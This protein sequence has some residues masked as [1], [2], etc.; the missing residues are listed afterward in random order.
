[1]KYIF[2]LSLLFAYISTNAQTYVNYAAGK[3][4]KTSWKTKNIS[5]M[6]D[7]NLSTGRVWSN[8]KDFVME[9]DLTAE[10]NIGGAQLY[11]EKAGLATPTDILIEY[12]NIKGEWIV[13]TETQVSKNYTY[14]LNLAFSKSYSTSAIRIRGKAKSA[15]GIAEVAIW[16]EQI[17]PLKYGLAFT[18]P[19]AFMPKEH[20]ICANQVTY[21][22]NQP[23]AFTV[24]TAK[25]DLHYTIVEAGT[26]LQ[27]YEA[28]L[29]NKK[30]VFSDFNPDDAEG[31]SYI[32]QIEGDGF[33][34]A[35]SYPFWIGEH[36]VQENAYQITTD[37]FTDV[38]SMVGTHRSAYGGSAWR[39]GAYYTYEVPSM[40]MMYLSNTR[41][42][43]EMN[44]TLDWEKEKKY[45][46]SESYNK[47]GKDQRNDK[48]A[49]STVKS[50]YADYPSPSQ[51]APDLIKNILF[52]TLWNLT[53]PVQSDPSGDKSGWMMHGQTVEQFAYFLYGYPEMEEYINKDIYAQILD[54]TLIWW[55]EVGLLDIIT[56]VGTGKGR[57]CPGHSIMPNLLMYEVAK[58]ENIKGAK[59]YLK[60]AVNQTQW[61]IENVDWS[62]P[63]YSKGQ[64]ISE[65]KLITGLALMQTNYSKESPKGLSEFLKTWVDR[66]IQLSDNEWDFR[67]FDLNENWTIPSYNEAGN[68]IA[69]PACALSVA[70][71]MENSPKKDRLVEIAYAHIDNY[72][73]RNP[74]NAHCA[75]HPNHG[76]T[77][78]ERGWQHGD[79]RRDICARLETTRGSLSSLPGSEMY[80]FNPL[81]KPRWGE[82]WTSYNALWNLSIT[83]LNFYEGVAD[84]EKIL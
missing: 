52:G 44:T 43:K 14:H 78:I 36:K 31:K 79:K 11:F 39:D 80:P 3:T 83:Y 12:K 32:I 49:L 45:V 42:F 7:E 58:R 37:F 72:S 35:S 21:N 77:G 5:L 25:T 26:G 4:V 2:I 71:T 29:K 47:Q 46:L 15:Y 65:H 8:A 19:V 38:R 17:P 73:G 16:G 28:F 82:G 33:P 6:T 62:D 57:H 84:I 40:V 50:I 18:P 13:A 24:P 30:G 34:M 64:R 10:F 67:R 48:Y 75:N 1:M 22:L 23:K 9:I 56:K 51:D 60:A 76:F 53:Q 27:V 20:W 63:V 61:I 68:I 74:A 55:N 69:F 81:G 41:I 66:T 70:L 59:K 54:S